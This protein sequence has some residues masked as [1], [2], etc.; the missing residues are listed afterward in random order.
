MSDENLKDSQAKM[1]RRIEKLTGRSAEANLQSAAEKAA[2]PAR[3]NAA[4]T[5]AG[6]RQQV[7]VVSIDVPFGDI[8]WLTFKALFASIVVCLAL[9]IPAFIIFDYWVNIR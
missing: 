5:V 7:D 4:Q 3:A 8:F 2:N 6:N 1:R 9:A